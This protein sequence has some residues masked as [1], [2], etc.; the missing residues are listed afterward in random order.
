MRIRTCRRTPSPPSWGQTGQKNCAWAFLYWEVKIH[1]GFKNKLSTFYMWTRLCWLQQLLLKH[2]RS[3]S[4]LIWQERW[5][6]WR[7]E[8]MGV[9]IYLECCTG[10]RKLWVHLSG[11]WRKLEEKVQR[12]VYILMAE[13]G[14]RILLRFKQPN[15]WSFSLMEGIWKVGWR[16]NLESEC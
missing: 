14:F 8:D 2:K 11:E 5:K 10:N 6:S 9:G 1:S 13:R 3:E 7:K 16:Y 15:K 4:F 12:K